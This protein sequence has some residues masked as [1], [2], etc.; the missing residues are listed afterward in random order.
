MDDI[1]RQLIALL[2]R[3]AR[4]PIATPATKL[5]VSRG[6]MGKRLRNLEDSLVIVGYSLRHQVALWAWALTAS[7]YAVGH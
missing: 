3:D 7:S 1:D 6:T 4:T 2:R 5:G